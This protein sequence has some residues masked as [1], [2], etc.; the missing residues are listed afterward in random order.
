[1]SV[2]TIGYRECSVPVFGAYTLDDFER[3]IPIVEGSVLRGDPTLTQFLV[4]RSQKLLNE[5]R[6]AA[7]KQRLRNALLEGINNSN[8]YLYYQQHDRDSLPRQ[9]AVRRDGH[10]IQKMFVAFLNWL[11]QSGYRYVANPTAVWSLTADE[12]FNTTLLG[13]SSRNV[14]Y[15][16]MESIGNCENVANGFAMTLVC[17]GVPRSALRLAY[18]EATDPRH[19][20]AYHGAVARNAIRKGAQFFSTSVA[21]R[22]E[23]RSKVMIA[24]GDGFVPAPTSEMDTPFGNHWVVKASGTL[25]DG[26]YACRYDEPMHV[27]AAYDSVE[28]QGAFIDRS[29]ESVRAGRVLMPVEGPAEYLVEVVGDALATEIKKVTG[30]GDKHAYVL[31]QPG[32]AG[33]HADMKSVDGR[34]WAVPLRVSRE[35]GYV[36]PENWRAD[37][38]SKSFVE[39]AVAT[40]IANYRNDTSF[41]NQKSTESDAFLK[42]AV[43]W[44]GIGDV[45]C[46]A[47]KSKFFEKDNLDGVVSLPDHIIFGNLYGVLGFDP[48][49]GGAAGNN[50]VGKRLRGF[51]LNAF[52]VPARIKSLVGA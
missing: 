9:Y 31:V 24:D 13:G 44:I 25:W 42:S 34:T 30:W 41:W 47:V 19:E 38:Y 48:T 1:M 8:P 10:F 28:L 7:G 15:N 18:V 26:N 45:R 17:V 33:C 14:L 36:I 50:I 49:T 22:N 35:W 4:I 29:G 23:Y 11:S 37:P 5:R 46:K 16:P 2:K 52:G 12:Q 6:S 43:K 51:L 21:N 3:Y 40:A 32:R 27:C 39:N 20:F